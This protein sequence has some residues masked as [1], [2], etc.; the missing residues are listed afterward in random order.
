MKNNATIIRC[1][2][3]EQARGADLSGKIYVKFSI[4]SDGTVSRARVTTSRFAGTALDT[5]ISNEVNALKFPPY[6]GKSKQI[7][8]PLIVE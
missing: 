6:E 8:Y 4:S 2:K 3:V 1:L 7:T 5:C